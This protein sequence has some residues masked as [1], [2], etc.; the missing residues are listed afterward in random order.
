MNKPLRKLYAYWKFFFA[1]FIHS[2]IATAIACTELWLT[3]NNSAKYYK[4]FIYSIKHH[5]YIQN[6]HLQSKRAVYLSIILILVYFLPFH[7][8]DL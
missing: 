8:C 3:P 6:I 1:S 4:Y 2:V 7:S 5:L